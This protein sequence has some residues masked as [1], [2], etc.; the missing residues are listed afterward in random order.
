MIN[1]QFAHSN[2]CTTASTTI[3]LQSHLNSRL[4][5]VALPI[6]SL[7][8]QVHRTLYLLEFPYMSSDLIHQVKNHGTK[9]GSPEKVGF[10]PNFPIFLL[11]SHV[12]KK[13][14][15]NHFEAIKMAFGINFNL[16]MYYII[17]FDLLLSMW[18]LDWISFLV[19]IQ[20]CTIDPYRNRSGSVIHIH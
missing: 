9:I 11:F 3:Y 15:K 2:V 14:I 6:L 13:Q 8:S 12:A 16:S 4:I 20:N 7:L 10:F 18:R 5:P 19:Q 1:S 17:A